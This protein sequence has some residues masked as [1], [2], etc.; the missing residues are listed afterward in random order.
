MDKRRDDQFIAAF[1]RSGS[2]WLRTMVANIIDPSA[3]SDPAIFNRLIPSTSI[4]NTPRVR[5][6]PSP[7]IVMTHS[8]WR[9]S[10]P[11]AV[12]LVRDGRDVLVSFYYYTIVRAGR[13]ES[14]ADFYA[15]YSAGVFGP[16]WDRHVASW[17]GRARRKL[18]SDLLTIRFEELKKSPE[19]VLDDVV[20]FLG[21]D[22]SAELRARAVEDASLENERQIESQRHGPVS[23]GKSF[24]RGG[25]VGD[26]QTFVPPHLLEH[27][28]SHGAAKALRQVG[29]A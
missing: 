27:F 11:R 17:F 5:S 20:G 23:G 3:R 6:R 28:L 18:G 24:Y 29:Y 14:F 12:Y 21:L 10:I 19:E 1:P 9:R 25:R 26:W 15:M 2:T 16:R 8:V 13:A 7:R 22:T 4:R